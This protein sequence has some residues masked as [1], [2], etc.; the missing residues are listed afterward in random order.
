MF[1]ACLA[2]GV[3][4]L[5]AWTGAIP[6]Y[7]GTFCSTGLC[8]EHPA[9]AQ[10]L[11]DEHGVPTVIGDSANDIFALH[12][13][14]LGQDRLWQLHQVRISARGRLAEIKAQALKFDVF[15]RQIGF[16]RLGVEDWE[17]IRG[18][19]EHATSVQ[20][21]EAFVRGINWAAKRRRGHGEMFML[22]GSRWEDLTPEDLCAMARLVSFYMSS[23]YQHVLVRQWMEAVFG[24][25]AGDEWT[26]TAD[27]SPANPPTL[28]RS[29][30]EAFAKLS[31]SDVRWSQGPSSTRA[32]QG[33]NWFIVDGSRSATGGLP[34]LSD[35]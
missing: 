18:E 11:R 32:G 28:S 33:S 2:A 6:E 19:E 35:I 10:I 8:L 14:C 24:E 23:G 34:E 17:T 3:R 16:Y 15:A 9:S 13:V 4:M 25:E 26:R 22:T 30:R 5:N 27:L 20:M 29:A 1:S 31:P 21:V 7:Q 12:G